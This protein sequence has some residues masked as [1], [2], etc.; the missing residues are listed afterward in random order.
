MSRS[1]AMRRIRQAMD[2]QIGRTSTQ[3]QLVSRRSLLKASGLALGGV[4]AARGLR[5]QSFPKAAAPRI[6]II[7]AGIGGM[8]AALTLQDAA[9]PCEVYESSERIGGRM[10]SNSGF[11][12]ERQCSEWCGEFID[13]SNHTIR[14]LAARFGLQLVDVNAAD[15]HNSQDTNYFAGGYY[16]DAELAADMQVLAPIL[17]EQNRS[18]GALATYSS[19]TAAGY[20]FD[21]LSAHDW[22]D[23]YVPGGHTS[24]LGQYLDV[25][26][27][28]ENGLDTRQQSSLNLIFPLDSDE[29]FH[30]RNGNEQLPLAIGASL[31]SG[32]VRSGWRLTA[33]ATDN[34]NGSPVTLTFSTG[35][36]LRAERFDFVIL[37]L[38]FSV[39]RGLDI[40]DAGF[41]PLKVQAINQLGYGTNSKLILQFD[42]RYWNGRGAWPGIGDGFLETD[43]RFQSTWDSSRAEP[44][45][46]GLLTNYTGGTPGAAFRPHGPYTTS[47]DSG[48]TAGY[49]QEFLGELELAWPGIG[50]HYTGLATLS[51]P[52]GDPNLLG[53]YSTYKVGQ[54]TQFG[55]YEKVPEGPIHFAGEHT[56][57]DFQGFMEGGARSGQRAAREILAILA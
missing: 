48:T 15:P 38:P 30:I 12:G 46:D 35:T 40:R 55:D 11:W 19:F 22:I 1:R 24:R 53:S 56:S 54:Y 2:R 37:A 9:I 3:D 29:R 34:G 43:L 47:R 33:I 31:P 44:G 21:N 17:R 6:A 23:N 26:T 39:L 28:T 18:I 45:R 13:T 8:V 27:V 32:T 14:S 50:D 7:G 25:A 36:D 57:Y 42:S 10:H 5:A 16:T 4:F 51:Y 41:S 52:T 49:A 20:Y